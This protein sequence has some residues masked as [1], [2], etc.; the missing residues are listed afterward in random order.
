MRSR[1]AA[2]G[3]TNITLQFSLDRDVEAAAQDVNAA[4]GKTLPY[5][6]VHDSAAELSQA[7]SVGHAD[8]EHCA[9][10]ER[11]ADDSGR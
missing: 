10:V 2:L 3:S 7:E 4:I 6:A 9:H 8:P 11:V 1:R 5:P